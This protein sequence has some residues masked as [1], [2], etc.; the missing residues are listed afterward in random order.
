M[1]TMWSTV[2]RCVIAASGSEMA[3]RVDLKLQ[4]KQ[5]R[6]RLSNGRR[7]TS[8]GELDVLVDVSG[9]GR[10]GAAGQDLDAISVEQMQ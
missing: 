6:N 2:V 1:Q 9:G 3:G 5:Q 7:R 4:Q 10:G 8:D